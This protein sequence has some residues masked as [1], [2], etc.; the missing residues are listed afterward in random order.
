MRGLPENFNRYTIDKNVCEY[1]SNIFE[2]SNGLGFEKNVQ[3]SWNS[4][5][6]DGHLI[7][8]RMGGTKLVNF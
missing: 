8:Q 1:I 3:I 2:A 7:S 4:W 6:L 5:F